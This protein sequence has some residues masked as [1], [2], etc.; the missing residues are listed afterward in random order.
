[1]TLEGWQFELDPKLRVID[2]V[3]TLVKYADTLERWYE[4]LE[5]SMRDTGVYMGELAGMFR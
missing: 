3:G 4:T 5:V 2:K 1:M